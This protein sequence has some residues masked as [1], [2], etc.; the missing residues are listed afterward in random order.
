[1]IWKNYVNPTL[2]SK[3]DEAA[4]ELRYI[5]RHVQQDIE[6]A[7]V[8]KGVNRSTKEGQEE[9]SIY[10]E[11]VILSRTAAGRIEKGERGETEE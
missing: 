5:N 1:M 3:Y 6:D 11:Y 4:H 2:D 8:M 9:Y 10:S 7:I